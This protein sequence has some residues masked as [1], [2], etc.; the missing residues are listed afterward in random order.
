M[1]G[2]FRAQFLLRLCAQEG[3]KPDEGARRLLGL[4]E[5][6]QTRDVLGGRVARV[7]EGKVQDCLAAVRLGGERLGRQF[8]NVAEDHLKSAPSSSPAHLVGEEHVVAIVDAELFEEKLANLAPAVAGVVGPSHLG[9][10]VTVLDRPGVPVSI[11]GCDSDNFVDIVLDDEGSGGPI[12]NACAAN[13]SSPPNYTPNNSLTAFEGMNS[14]GDWVITV[15]DSATPDPGTL[16]TWSLH[17][18]QTGNNP[19]TA[20][21][22]TD[23][24]CSDG[25]FCNGA[26]VCSGGSCEAGPAV[27]T[28]SCEHCDEGASACALC[29]TDLDGD[30]TIGVSDISV[31]TGCF[32]A[33]YAP[34]DPCASANVDGDV[35]GCVGTGDY[36]ALVGCMNQ[37]C[38]ACSNCTGPPGG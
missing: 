14:D 37:T 28:A 15:Y 6:I 3:R 4:A 19:C 38:G 25:V 34:A 24:Q 8:A 27:C 23:P 21:C 11:F 1:D 10:T 32:G 31:L 18:D 16:N 36:S 20:E 12:E 13:L 22:S 26:E 5:L 2:I 17:I 30:G 7:I 35:G 29:A 33:C 9:T